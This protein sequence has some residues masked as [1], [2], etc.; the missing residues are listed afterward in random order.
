[1]RYIFI[2]SLLL[3]ESVLDPNPD[4]FLTLPP[5]SW[6]TKE[7]NKNKIKITVPKLCFLRKT[8]FNVIYR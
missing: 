8:K 6:I 5:E 3:T 4:L 1:M 7:Q 2:F